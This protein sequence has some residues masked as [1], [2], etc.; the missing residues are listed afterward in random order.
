MVEI[1]Q[2]LLWIVFP[3]S[4][5]A[6]FGMGLIWQFETP[7]AK[8]WSVGE[9]ILTISLIALLG[10]CT[11]TGLAM[12]YVSDE[13]AQFFLWMISLVQ[14]Q[15]DMGLVMSISILPKIHFI[16]ALLFLLSLA[17][18]R[19]IVYLLKPHLLIKRVFT[20]VQYIKRHL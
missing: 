10:L 12:V 20:R 3:Y 19:Q 18:S 6:I 13:Y 9:K 16:I 14:L 17:F 11:I 7:G 2:S 8:P 4:V 1:Y 15:P 5:V